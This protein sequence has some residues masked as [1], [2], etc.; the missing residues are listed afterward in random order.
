MSNHLDS[1][2]RRP[3]LLAAGLLGLGALTGCAGT[4]APPSAAPAPRS[5]KDCY[6][7][8]SGQG[9]AFECGQVNGAA[10]DSKEP[11]A[12]ALQAYVVEVRQSYAGEG[13]VEGTAMDEGAGR[14]PGRGA[15][16]VRV[17]WH[18]RPE[19]PVSEGYVFGFERPEG[20]TRVASCFAADG[21]QT[22]WELCNALLQTAPELP[23]PRALLGQ[24]VPVPEGCEAVHVR[25]G[26]YGVACEEV[27]LSWTRIDT[28]AD[29][30][31]ADRLARGQRRAATAVLEDTP[32]SCRARGQAATCQRLVVDRKDG[33]HG[34]LIGVLG[35]ARHMM[36]LTCEWKNAGPMPAMCSDILSVEGVSAP[37]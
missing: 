8:P 13:D 10:G 17:Q 18:N 37:R 29:P 35:D 11:V 15:M 31:A 22:P 7:R 30:A 36:V 2:L 6:Q 12:E 24:P 1:P 28:P 33:R 27:N 14:V 20:G 4:Q 5:L 34:V 23:D 32:V 26:A 19:K 25:S 21:G 3:A 9:L 16:R